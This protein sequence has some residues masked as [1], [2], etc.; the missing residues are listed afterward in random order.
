MVLSGSARPGQAARATSSPA[1]RALPCAPR[2]WRRK[3]GSSEAQSAGA[4]HGARVS[5]PRSRVPSWEGLGRT[6]LLPTVSSAGWRPHPRAD[7][8][9][10]VHVTAL[11]SAQFYKCAGEMKGARNSNWRASSEK[12]LTSSSHGQREQE[13]EKESGEGRKGEG[14]KGGTREAGKG[15]RRGRGRRKCG[16]GKVGRG[17]GKRVG[18]RESE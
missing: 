10:V 7:I 15:E 1:R 6:P 11:Q 18:D 2:P 9:L 16:K 5:P 14:R 8:S 3:P 12:L 4:P 17:R 13:G